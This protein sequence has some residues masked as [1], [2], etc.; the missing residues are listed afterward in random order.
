MRVLSGNRLR[1]CWEQHAD[2]EQALKAW[3]AEAR[4]ATWTCPNDIKQR[5]RS[6]DFLADNRVVFNIKGNKYRLVAKIDYRHQV[7]RIRFVGI[8]AEYVRINA[9]TV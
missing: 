6:A 2:V 8:H 5:Y 4:T 3:Y 7:I 9:E 1:S